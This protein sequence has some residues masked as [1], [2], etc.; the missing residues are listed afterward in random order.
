MVETA[1]RG[2]KLGWEKEH[3]L[4]AMEQV[5]K[6]TLTM[7]SFSDLKYLTHSGRISHLKGIFGS[8]LKIKPIIGMN[9]EDGRYYNVGQDMTV[10]RSIKKM[11]RESTRSVRKPKTPPPTDAR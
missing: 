8:L 7:V 1:A 2:I 11:C 5:K 9:E 4:E 3:I 6:N 10:S